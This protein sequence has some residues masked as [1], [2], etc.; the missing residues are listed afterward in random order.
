[1]SLKGKEEISRRYLYTGKVTGEHSN[2]VGSYMTRQALKAA[3]VANMLD[4]HP[5][6]LW[7]NKILLLNQPG[8][9]Y[10]GMTMLE[11]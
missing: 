5:A 6:E 8:L 2:L 10:V 7:E 4:F 1:M 11:N 3:E 9:K